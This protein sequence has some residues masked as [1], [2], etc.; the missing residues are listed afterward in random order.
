M[1]KNAWQPIE[2]VNKSCRDCHKTIWFDPIKKKFFN[3]SDLKIFHS[4]SAWQP[5]PTAVTKQDLIDISRQLITVQ[6]SIGLLSQE[7]RLSRRNSHESE[8]LMLK[9]FEESEKNI[10]NEI[11]KQIKN[12]PS[13]NMIEEEE[14]GDHE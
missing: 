11:W 8:Q 1:T 4:C 9:K 12:I 10:L 5:K 14:E 13:L 2:I 3:D 7:I 6:E